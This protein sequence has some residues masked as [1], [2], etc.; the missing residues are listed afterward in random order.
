[1]ME[2]A[3]RVEKLFRVPPSGIPEQRNLGSCT[4]RVRGTC[5]C[6]VWRETALKLRSQQTQHCVVQ[7]TLTRARLIELD[8]SSSRQPDVTRYHCSPRIDSANKALGIHESKANLKLEAPTRTC[9]VACQTTSAASKASLRTGML[10]L[11]TAVL[12]FPISVPTACT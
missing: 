5:T 2:Q 1:M 4:C 6:Q 12:R 8:S 9:F 10:C 11:C 3:A 7:R